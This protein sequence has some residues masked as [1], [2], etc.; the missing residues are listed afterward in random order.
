MSSTKIIIN[1]SKYGLNIVLIRSMKIADAFF[2]LNDSELIQAIYNQE[3]CLPNPQLMVPR[4]EF[5]LREAT[6]SSWLIE[7][8]VGSRQ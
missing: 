2:N 1:L 7:E 3:G 6:S 4:P 8:I 5:Y